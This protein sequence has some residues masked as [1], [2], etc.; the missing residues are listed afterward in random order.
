MGEWM[1]SPM[2]FHYFH[3]KGKRKETEKR[4]EN[5]EQKNCIKKLHTFRMGMG[6]LAVILDYR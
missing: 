2:Y 1:Y 6:T 3:K 4:K 5:R